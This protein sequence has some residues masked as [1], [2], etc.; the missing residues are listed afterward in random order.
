MRHPYVKRRVGAWE[1]CLT[2]EKASRGSDWQRADWDCPLCGS[3]AWNMWAWSTVRAVNPAYPV[4]PD[5]GVLYPLY[6][7]RAASERQASR[8]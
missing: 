8:V 2:C 3:G 1:W 7:V 5:P 4:K 6:P